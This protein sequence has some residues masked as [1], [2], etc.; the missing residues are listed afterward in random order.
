MK[1]CIESVDHAPSS[2]SSSSRHSPLNVCEDGES[3]HVAR[4]HSVNLGLLNDFHYILQSLFDIRY[5]N[6]MA[7][8]GATHSD[9]SRLTA[10][11][12]SQPRSS[13]HP[14]L[15]G[16]SWRNDG[17]LDSFRLPPLLEASLRF[18]SC[19]AFDQHSIVISGCIQKSRYH[20]DVVHQVCH[21]LFISRFVW[22]S[23]VPWCCSFAHSLWWR[24]AIVSRALVF[25]RTQLHQNSCTWKTSLNLW[26]WISLPL[27]RI[28]VPN[29]FPMMTANPLS[30]SR[31]TLRIGKCTRSNL[32][33]ALE[34]IVCP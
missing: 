13:R 18:T 29:S 11:P 27:L 33:T 28:W 20:D 7:I 26:R 14:L 15:V 17:Q 3:G 2:I 1:S 31:L 12:S 16:H 30:I 24:S 19:F 5:G 8:S 22:K 34:M 25:Q 32:N 9:N 6:P 4:T 21:S 10:T 23:S